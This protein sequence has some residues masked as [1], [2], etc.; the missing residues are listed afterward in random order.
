M[1]PPTDAP[2]G[3]L[4]ADVVDELLSAELDG[5]FDAAARDHGFAPAVA[6]ARLAATPGV[7]AR[8]TALETARAALTQ[9]PTPLGADARSALL[10]AI[11]TPGDELAARRA[12]RRPRRFA[13]IAVAA[14]A[15]ALVVGL[16]VSVVS[17]S[18][19]DDDDASAGGG[20]AATSAAE[21]AVT[22]PD[23]AG[24][25]DSALSAAPPYAF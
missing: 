19:G 10:A 8:R 4:A 9:T 23:A 20:S 22:S 14:A 2:N 18:N 17:T 13:G 11:P 3:P 6:R 12:R 25:S 15:I 21:D 5:A 24:G 7:D 1:T 16:A